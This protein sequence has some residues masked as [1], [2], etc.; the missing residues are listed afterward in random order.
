MGNL[1]KKMGS[2]L[3]ISIREESYWISK[4][5]STVHRF[6]GNILNVPVGTLLGVYIDFHKKHLIFKDN[7]THS[8]VLDT[9]LTPQPLWLSHWFH[10]LLLV[11]CG[12]FIIEGVE[13]NSGEKCSTHMSKNSGVLK[14]LE[15]A[16]RIHEE[17]EEKSL[18]VYEMD[19]TTI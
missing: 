17:N 13:V 11:N 10:Y 19:S 7:I 8:V 4:A 3:L 12:T 16:Q 9:S 14:A 1:F 5:I 18:Q 6:G 15:I 2:S